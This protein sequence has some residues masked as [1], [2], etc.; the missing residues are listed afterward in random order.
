M[1]LA[2][3][4]IGSEDNFLTEAWNRAHLDAA[5]KSAGVLRM[6]KL[7]SADTGH[8]FD[9]LKSVRKWWVSLT[10]AERWPIPRRD[11]TL[12]RSSDID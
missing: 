9:I 6:V 2:M 7:A 5:K 10:V 1:P 8:G 3:R 12:P 4:T 11:M